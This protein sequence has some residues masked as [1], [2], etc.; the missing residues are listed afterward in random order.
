M[1]TQVDRRL[2]VGGVGEFDPAQ[3]DAV[4]NLSRQESL[5]NAV[6][7][8]G[9]ALLDIPQD[10]GEPVMKEWFD[11]FIEFMKRHQEER[12]GI[13]C[14]AGMSRSVGYTVAWFVVRYG[15]RW[16]TALDIIRMARN[17]VRCDPAPEIARTLKEYTGQAYRPIGT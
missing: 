5:T 13:I 1:L 7:A 10:D 17:H 2:F 9:L 4:V 3:V 6:K 16:D 14:G 15:L 12:V 8:Q 11:S